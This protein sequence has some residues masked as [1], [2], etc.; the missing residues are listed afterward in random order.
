MTI[1]NAAAI[2]EYIDQNNLSQTAFGKRIGVTQSMVGQW[3]RGER[4]VS[5]KCAL[6]I[7]KEFEI[8]ASQLSQVVK[9]LRITRDKRQEA[10]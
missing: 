1:K 5:V 7:E 8:D 10:A 4:P 6:A 9:S 2:R 3:I